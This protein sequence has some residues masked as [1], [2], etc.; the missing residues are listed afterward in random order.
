MKAGAVK[1]DWA[2]LLVKD[3]WTHEMGDL[4]MA[5]VVSELR[6]ARRDGRLDQLN[7]MWNWLAEQ[8]QKHSG[9]PGIYPP[10][11]EKP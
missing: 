1:L 4:V 9:Y 3:R 8:F 6:K 10:I 11:E 5:E 7:D 2:E